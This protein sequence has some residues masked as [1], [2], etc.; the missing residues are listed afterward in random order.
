MN[1]G[2]LAQIKLLSNLSP[3]PLRAERAMLYRLNCCVKLCKKTLT[4]NLLSTLCK[5]RTGL[6][7]V[8]QCIQKLYKQEDNK[9]VNKVRQ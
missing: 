8:E 6:K 7:D 2:T 1:R 9:R 3:D 5:K 4:R